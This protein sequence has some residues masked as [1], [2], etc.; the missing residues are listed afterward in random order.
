MFEWHMWTHSDDVSKFGTE[1]SGGSLVGEGLLLNW[2][3][4][5]SNPYAWNYN[6]LFTYSCE[7][8][9]EMPLVLKKFY[10]P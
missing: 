6:F 1:R 10:K 4:Y 7:C 5:G 3:V 2:E 8:L 9:V